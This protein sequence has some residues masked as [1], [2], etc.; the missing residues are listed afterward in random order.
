M[1]G[2]SFG[3]IFRITTFGESHG[4]GLGTIIDG[5]PAGIPVDIERIQHELDRRKPGTPDGGQRNPAV[6][7]RTEKDKVEILS[8]VFNGLSEGTPIALLIRNTSQRSSDYTKIRNMFR[9][10]HADYTYF[11]KYGIRDYRGGGRSS[12]RET[13]GRVAAGAVARMVLSALFAGKIALHAYTLEAAGIPCNSIS[14]DDIDQNPLRAAD[15]S[16]AVQMAEKIETYR[17]EGNSCGGIIECRIT[18]IPA[19]LGEPVFDK[20]DAELAQAVL[21]IGAVKG[22]EFGTGFA[23][24]R[25][26]GSVN[27]DNMRISKQSGKPAFVTNNSGGILGGISNGNEIV[28]RA[29]IKPVP[30]IFIRQETVSLKT[31]GTE[32]YEDADIVIEGRHDVCLCPR[33]VPVIEAMTAVVLADAALRNRAAKI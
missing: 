30:S 27:N 10:G 2:N 24:A 11:K 29:A 23:A 28:F 3:Q 4:P 14:F 21:S 5:C 32:D 33:I 26:F 12:G 15:S 8:G 13:A 20:L 17:K 6:T 18:G 7:S 16:A 25:S 1:A 22:I 31:P 19:G 9:P